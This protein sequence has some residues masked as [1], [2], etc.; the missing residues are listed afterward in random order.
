MPGI[1]DYLKHSPTPPCLSRHVWDSQSINSL[2][3]CLMSQ[4]CNIMGPFH[5]DCNNVT[6]VTRHITILHWEA[7][8]IKHGCNQHCVI[9]S[10]PGPGAWSHLCS[11]I[12]VSEIASNVPVIVTCPALYIAH[13][14]VRNYSARKLFSMSR[15]VFLPVRRGVL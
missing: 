6:L 8:D 12:L 15:R 11:L 4:Y 5:C 10:L 2:L 7:L 3:Q 9:S 13:S 1:R 14:I